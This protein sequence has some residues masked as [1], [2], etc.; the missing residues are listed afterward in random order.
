MRAVIFCL[1]VIGVPVTLMVVSSSVSCGMPRSSQCLGQLLIPG[2][3][4][5]WFNY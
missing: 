3:F 2:F 4:S 5:S 1:R